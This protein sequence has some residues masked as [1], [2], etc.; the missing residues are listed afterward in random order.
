M[1]SIPVLD[2]SAEIDVMWED[3]TQAIQDVLKSGAFILGPN[4]KAFEE[5]MASFLQVDH[6][7]GVNSGSDALL[8][9][10]HALGLSEGD[11]VI[12]TPFT[13]TATAGAIR[14][15]GARPVFVDI[16]PDTFNLNAKAVESRVTQRTRAI[17]PVH[18]FGQTVDMDPIVEIAN[19]HELRILEDA[20]QTI[21]GDYKE[22][23]VGA[24]GDIAAFSFFP[25]KNLGGFGD[26]GLIATTNDELAEAA[27]SLRAHGARR[28]YYAERVGYNSRLDEIQAAILRVKL[29]YLEG[30]I[31]RRREIA[32]FYDRELEGV[33]GLQTPRKSPWSRHT[34][35]QYTVRITNSRRDT[36]R[37]AL[38]KVGISTMV[39]YPHALHRV[40]AFAQDQRFP[41]AERAV[42]EVLS[43]PLWPLMGRDLQERVVEQLKKACIASS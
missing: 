18:L 28:K 4:V 11:E 25:T 31:T 7:I 14:L 3:L 22:R 29:P 27:R 8:I 13:F 5:E 33:S 23:P 41:M 9:A 40:P 34:Y 1:E 2:L 35:H 36:I 21:G 17:L 15:L 10:L 42:E 16:D 32:R 30:W 26:G 24:L 12:T 6:A 39:Y 20:A 38:Q 43:L 19:K 37:E